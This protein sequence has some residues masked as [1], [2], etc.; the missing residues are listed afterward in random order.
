MNP[1]DPTG[2]QT[3]AIKLCLFLGYSAVLASFSFY[4]GC[5]HK[6]KQYEADRA[7]AQAKIALQKQRDDQEGKESS[8]G[9]KV[10]QEKDYQQFE[11]DKADFA[12]H[13]G[14]VYHYMAENT[15]LKVQLGEQPTTV[16]VTK[17]K[18]IDLEKACG[19]LV[20]NFGASYISLYDNSFGAGNVELRAGADAGA[21][22]VPVDQAF[23]ETIAKN[24]R[25]CGLIRDQ[26]KSLQARIRGKQSTFKE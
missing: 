13:K 5:E 3:A 8:L 22:E 4:S 11:H 16:V 1:L 6:G 9:L 20:P 15:N 26:L 12:K 25:T 23:E 24:N 21:T 14:L 10:K 17:D 18:E 2:L 7:A 19:N